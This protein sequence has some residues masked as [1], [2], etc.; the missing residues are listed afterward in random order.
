MGEE[1]RAKVESPTWTLSELLPACAIVVVLLTAAIIVLDPSDHSGVLTWLI[2]AALAFAGYKVTSYGV[3]GAWSESRHGSAFALAA[4]GI[5]CLCLAG[6]AVTL[7]D[8]GLSIDPRG[9]AGDPTYSEASQT[10]DSRPG[11][12]IDDSRPGSQDANSVCPEGASCGTTP[13][14]NPSDPA[15]P[16]GEGYP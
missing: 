1:R 7:N 12:Q 2:A 14:A 16:F 3:Q 5:V 13:N 4:V 11:S 15:I 6:Q 8:V 10:D 9:T